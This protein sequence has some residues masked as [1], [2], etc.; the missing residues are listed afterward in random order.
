MATAVVRSPVRTIVIVAFPFSGVENEFDEKARKLACGAGPV[1]EHGVNGDEKVRGVGSLPE[2]SLRLLFVSV[3]PPP[4][5]MSDL[6]DGGGG[7]GD[8][9][10]AQAFGP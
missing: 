10:S 2:K 3:H 8:P 6:L 5:R 9:P 7:R 4:F 1:P